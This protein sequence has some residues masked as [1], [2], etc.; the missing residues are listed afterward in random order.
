MRHTSRSRRFSLQTA[1]MLVGSVLAIDAWAA[2]PIP[3][4]DTRNEAIAR[5][6]MDIEPA[7]ASPGQ[8]LTARGT[9]TAWSAETRTVEFKSE[10]SPAPESIAVK[11]IRFG[12]ETPSMV[13]QVPRPTLVRKGQVSASFR[14]TDV[15]IS[16]G[17][18]HF[19]KCEKGV[20]GHQLAFEGTLT[21]TTKEVVM[22]GEVVDV[23][24]PRAQESS[25]PTKRKGG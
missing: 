2:T 12:I 11:S 23:Q 6:Q 7:G 3:C 25:D 1:G 4:I 17:I 20:D 8:V 14:P 16:D 13:A 5:Q 15:R 24:A 10:I 22:K 21:F 18:V 9:L 19:P